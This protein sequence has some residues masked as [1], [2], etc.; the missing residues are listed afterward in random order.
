MITSKQP[1]LCLIFTAAFFLVLAPLL[2]AQNSPENRPV[3]LAWTSDE[4]AMRYEV[5]VEKETD[6]G[7]SQVLREFTG[8]SSIELSLP[9][10]KYRCRV[11]SYDFLEK[12]G[13]ES[14]WTSFEVKAARTPAPPMEEDIIIAQP[15]GEPA[16]G[17]QTPEL[18][19][20][21]PLSS[22]SRG[23]FDIYLSAAW[24]PLVPLYEKENEYF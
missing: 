17:E 1:L 19:P 5:T 10:G 18:L 21:P 22:A 24:M 2:W 3:H 11:T 12:P 16:A 15:S 23:I 20:E 14:G 8:I 4:Y 9:P 13:G 6:H 7:Y